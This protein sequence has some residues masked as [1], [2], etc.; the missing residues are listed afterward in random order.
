MGGR[1][2]ILLLLCAV[3]GRAQIIATIAGNHLMGFSGVGG[4]AVRAQLGMLYG[5]AVDKSGNVYAADQSN[6]VIWEISPGGIITLYAGTG[7]L[8]YSGD[9][10]AATQALLYQP[11]WLAMDP[12]GNLYF[13]DQQG[14]YI[15]K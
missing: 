2:V 13:T 7:I 9:G 14:I 12:G 15:R 1:F 10:G 11:A 3:G 5:V 8:G 4:P 6:N